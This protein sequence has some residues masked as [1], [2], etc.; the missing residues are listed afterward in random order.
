MKKSYELWVYVDKMSSRKL[1]PQR[2][3][4]SPSSAS[5]F[6][7]AHPDQLKAEDSNQSDANH[8]TLVLG[9]GA[10]GVGMLVLIVFFVYLYYSRVKSNRT[11]PY[12]FSGVRLQRFSY[13]EL[14][15]ATSSF[16]DSMKLGK[17]GFG[18]VYKGV[19]R[20]GKEVAVKKLDVSSLQGEREFQNELAIVG[21]LRS[22][23]IVSLLGYCADGKRRLLVY[24]YMQNRS[25][26]EA[27]FEKDD[28][29]LPGKLD[30]EKRFNIIIDVAQA[31]AFLHLDCD[32]PIIHGDVKPSNV[33]LD[34]NF[35]ARI[36]DFG[37]ARLKSDDMHLYHDMFSQDLGRSQEL[38]GRSQDLLKSQDLAK[39]IGSKSELASDDE[40]KIKSKHRYQGEGIIGRK[41]D[42]VAVD[43]NKPTKEQ[44]A[45][46]AQDVD[47]NELHAKGKE[48]VSENLSV[49]GSGKLHHLFEADKDWPCPS[50]ERT[51]W[52]SKELQAVPSDSHNKEIQKK[53]SRS[54]EWLSWKHDDSGELSTKDH[55][56]EFISFQIRHSGSLD[57][58]KGKKKRERRRF[59][60]DNHPSGEII[61]HTDSIR[62]TEGSEVKEKPR[63][64]KEWW[65]EEYFA[66]MSKKSKKMKKL[67]KIGWKSSNRFVSRKNSRTDSRRRDSFYDHSGDISFGKNRDKIKRD[68]SMGSE[69]WSGDLS[70]GDLSSVTSM[71]GTVCYIPPEY[72]GCGLL[73]EKGDIYSFG[74][75]MLVIVSGRRPLHV[76]ASPR[77]DFEKASL[78]PWARHLA[79]TGN[80]LEL[81]SES[82]KGIYD[83]DQAHLCITLGLLCLQKNPEMRPNISEIIKILKRQM[84]APSLP[85]E[86]SPST[87][88]R[89]Y[90]K[91]KKKNISDAVGPDVP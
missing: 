20:N 71:R 46:S 74:V 77:K 62:K 22:P 73:S 67:E 42:I 24:E 70:R 27:L 47:A 64:I 55:V 90:N 52:W 1:Y 6:Y 44:P 63:K 21:G 2:S 3:V 59:P 65:K 76:L 54:R 31:L 29:P 50:E 32:P 39:I 88:S 75:L 19:L 60:D 35:N 36:A 83:R 38:M 15:G 43:I 80:M 34:G 9:L 13:R 41:M 30:W 85:V 48:I 84:D 58:I 25:L 79:Q 40:S 61:N 78:I 8:Q 89:L 81:V 57:S 14:K 5:L 91:S 72:G 4:G 49:C 69:K 16:D 37:L 56:M 51:D 12:D 23:F 53:K 87:P 18:V 82:L 26:Q 86:F 17:G 7:G 68:Y 33:L 45:S 66:E 10:L 28:L 11:S